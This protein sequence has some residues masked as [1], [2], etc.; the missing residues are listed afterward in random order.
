VSAVHAVASEQQLAFVHAV[1]ASSAGAVGHV[2]PPELLAELTPPPDPVPLLEA[3]PHA[4]AI[5][6]AAASIPMT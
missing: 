5:A 1:H 3:P 4:P 6:P 2:A